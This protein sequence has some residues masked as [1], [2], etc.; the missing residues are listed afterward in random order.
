MFD[1]NT[2]AFRT[3]LKP[4]T[5]PYPYTSFKQILGDIAVVTSAIIAVDIFAA[6]AWLASSQALPADHFYLGEVTIT[7][8]RAIIL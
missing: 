3:P 4:V 8:L 5:P 7:I 2:P 6:I 1:I